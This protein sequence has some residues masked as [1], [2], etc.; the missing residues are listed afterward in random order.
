MGEACDTGAGKP[1]QR[2]DK[3]LC[4]LSRPYL[5]V[6]Y[7]GVKGIVSVWRSECCVFAPL[8]KEKHRP[9]GRRFYKVNEWRYGFFWSRRSRRSR[10]KINRWRSF[11]FPLSSPDGRQRPRDRLCFRRPR[12]ENSKGRHRAAHRIE[13]PWWFFRVKKHYCLVAIAITPPMFPVPNFVV[14]SQERYSRMVE[15]WDA[16][17]V[18]RDPIGPNSC[19]STYTVG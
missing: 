19:P 1:A 15:T 7:I 3:N 13:E 17:M 2:V 14:A 6:V 4:G 10:P 12:H 9:F 18:R 8:G 5:R 16:G 11:H